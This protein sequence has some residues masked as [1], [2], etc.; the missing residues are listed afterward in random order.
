MEQEDQR[1]GEVAAVARAYLGRFRDPMTRAMRDE[2]AQEST[3]LAW[4]WIRRIKDPDRLGAAVRTI[5]RRQRLR[6][7]RHQSPSGPN[8]AQSLGPEQLVLLTSRAPDP[9][10]FRVGARR[11]P[12]AW[13]CRRLAP[14]MARLSRLDQR[15]LMGFHEGFC[16]AELAARF[17][18]TEAC[19]KTRL[20]RARRRVQRNLEQL[21][22]VAASFEDSEPI[23]E[24]AGGKDLVR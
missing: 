19:V 17:G 9:L 12:A 2:I 1:W 4:Q 24:S 11:V 18:R 7:L 8:R 15:L 3:V 5:T 22:R 23:M 14:V 13:I 21:V 20:H 16:C 6:A 10:V